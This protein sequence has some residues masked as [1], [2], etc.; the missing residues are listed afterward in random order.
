ME[1]RKNRSSSTFWCTTRSLVLYFETSLRKKL[2]WTASSI[3]KNLLGLKKLSL[4]RK[5]DENQSRGF[6]S[7]MTLIWSDDG[8]LKKKS[9]LKCDKPSQLSKFTFLSIFLLNLRK[10][11]TSIFRLKLPTKAIDIC[12]TFN[13]RSLIKW[14]FAQQKKKKPKRREQ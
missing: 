9:W 7:W 3:R 14:K 12:P 4:G 10:I 11:L 5:D 1:K 6:L 13:P 8:L 2:P